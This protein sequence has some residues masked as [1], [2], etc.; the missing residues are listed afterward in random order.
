MNHSRSI[1]REGVKTG[2]AFG[3]LNQNLET[4]MPI[5]PCKD[6]LSDVVHSEKYGGRVQAY[7]LD[8]TKQ[9]IFN[10][11]AYIAIKVEDNDFEKQQLNKNYSKI[12]LLLNEIEAEIGLKP[13]SITKNIDDLFLVKLD[14]QW[15]QSNYLISIY[16]LFIRNG[17]K[18]DGSGAWE[19]VS[20]YHRDSDRAYF[21][22][23]DF[24]LILLN[25]PDQDLSHF[26][27]DTSVHNKGINSSYNEIYS[28][29]Y[30]KTSMA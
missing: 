12:Q 29:I 9:N 19:Y 18:Y 30:P 24:K 10:D 14:P 2:F 28:L 5:S 15:C 26:R 20:T 13:T 4:V 11:W 27:R 17:Y 22:N 6:Y 16:S 21:T 3:F 8:Y 23:K 25:R 1:L 7:G